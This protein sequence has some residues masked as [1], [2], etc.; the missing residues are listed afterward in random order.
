M[1]D[2]SSIT[3]SL[4]QLSIVWIAGE[5]EARRTKPK[6]P[7]EP[8]A[9]TQPTTSGDRPG[10]PVCEIDDL[11]W[12]ARGKLEQVVYLS[13]VSGEMPREVRPLVLLARQSME[14]ALGGVTALRGQV[15][16]LGAQCDATVDAI[17]QALAGLPHPD[18]MTVE[19]ASQASEAIADANRQAGVLALRFYQA[20]R[21]HRGHERM[22]D[23]YR[24]AQAENMPPDQFFDQLR[25]VLSDG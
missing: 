25:E 5:V 12:E 20:D 10:C 17:N 24:R 21:D 18:T 15:P 16:R 19:Q 9:P 23:L 14:K 22:S 4:T 11:L 1:I 13:S 3:R 7:F 6:N 8:P 2:W